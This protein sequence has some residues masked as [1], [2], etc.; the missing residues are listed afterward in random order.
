MKKEIILALVYIVLIILTKSLNI[1]SVL[2]TFSIIPI[3]ILLIL[4]GIKEPLIKENIFI[5]IFSIY[6]KILLYIAVLFIALNYPGNITI[7]LVAVVS[8]ISW[9]IITFIKKIEK[10]YKIQAIL[11]LNISAFIMSML[12]H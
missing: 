1:P 3:S 6:N 9:I 10:K 7:P 4:W 8:S 2:L 5:Q 12:L 11:Y